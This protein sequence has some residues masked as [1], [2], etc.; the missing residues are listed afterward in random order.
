MK[1]RVIEQN[2]GDLRK[3][4]KVVA[5]EVPAGGSDEI[6]GDSPN[7]TK[8]RRVSLNGIRNQSPSRPVDPVELKNSTSQSST[9]RRNVIQDSDDEEEDMEDAEDYFPDNHV[10]EH[11]SQS[12]KKSFSDMEKPE[13]TIQNERGGRA[14]NGEAES[15][16]LQILLERRIALE[17]ELLQINNEISRMR[18]NPHQQQNPVFSTPTRRKRNYPD[19]HKNSPALSDL[20]VNERIAE[21]RFTSRGSPLKNQHN[22]PRLN[23]HQD[24]TRNEDSFPN[25]RKKARASPSPFFDDE[26][27]PDFDQSHNDFEDIPDNPPP[28][29]PQSDDDYG[30]EPDFDDIEEIEDILSGNTTLPI[31]PPKQQFVKQLVIIS[32]DE[33]MGEDMTMDAESFGG[34]AMR[35][36]LRQSTL[37]QGKT[38]PKAQYQFLYNASQVDMNSNQMQHPW[39]RE[40]A[41]ALHER[42]GLSGFRS[43]QLEAINATLAGFDI[44]VLMPTGGGKSLI[45]QLPSVVRKGKTRGV[46]VVISPLV[47]LIQDQVSSLERKGIAVFH[48]AGGDGQAK[49]ERDEV[50]RNL[51]SHDVEDKIQM[52]YVTPEMICNNMTLQNAL[53]HLHDNGKFARLVVDE[54]HCVSQWGHDFRPEYKRIGGLRQNYPGVPLLALTATA[55]R[56]VKMDVM[57]NLSM[58]NCRVFTQSFNRPNITYTVL[59]K[60]KASVDRV[61]ELIKTS[62][63]RQCG[64]IYC[65]SRANCESV[66]KS[67]RDNKIKAAHYHAS[68]SN[69]ERVSTQQG[70]QSKRYDVI[71]AT[72]AFGMGIDKPDVRFVIHF[73]IPKSLEGYYQETGRAGRDGKPSSAYLFYSYGETH[74]LRRMIQSGDGDDLQKDRQLQ[75]LRSMV[76]YCENKTDCRRKQ[77]LNYFNENFNPEECGKTCDNCKAERHFV[78]KDVTTEAKVAV[79]IAVQLSMSKATLNHCIDI[80]RGSRNAKIMSSGHHNIVGFGDGKSWSKTDA[81]RLFTH[82]QSEDY[83]GF[84]FKVNKSGFYDAFV[85]VSFPYSQTKHH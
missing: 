3:A 14:A 69:E 48:I 56:D 80:F 49:G 1:P 29:P 5:V 46:T 50:I 38:T 23:S 83:I 58:K 27:D 66:A 70:W 26:Y 20:A 62:H 51:Y 79:N 82:L 17:K 54:A 42:F 32:D 15:G 16:R 24:F 65:T 61:I 21:T 10:E 74:L 34:P 72:I 78:Y 13:N 33:D 71:V 73:C 4:E 75:H 84:G 9:R 53:R 59:P 19:L 7:G 6:L 68:L 47:A 28:K 2:P 18:E 30:S 67:L 31:N 85:T 76:A 37:T 60:L 11:G 40:V 41:K 8:R 43:N 52:L 12:S 64:I 45:Y 81:E 36:P 35:T 57:K 77:V 22:S 44:F 55:T 39:S 25:P 63:P